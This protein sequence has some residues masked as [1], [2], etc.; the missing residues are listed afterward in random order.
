MGEKEVQSWRE[1]QP[2][3]SGLALCS[4]RRLQSLE[5]FQST[6]GEFINRK[7]NSWHALCLFCLSQ[8]CN[9]NFP[10]S[11]ALQAKET[12]CEFRAFPPVS[13]PHVAPFWENIS[14]ASRGAAEAGAYNQGPENPHSPN[15]SSSELFGCF[16]K[17]PLNA[18]GAEAPRSSRWRS[19]QQACLAKYPTVFEWSSIARLI[20]EATYFSTAGI[21][22][23]SLPAFA[24]SGE[25]NAGN[26][27]T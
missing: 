20:L 21:S 6:L 24:M 18:T 9:I 10:A 15:G 1:K 7:T 26:H 23:F 4:L 12:F 19:L 14:T 13:D 8:S 27:H 17:H 2:K 25:A 3:A 16:G 11:K 5:G 22:V